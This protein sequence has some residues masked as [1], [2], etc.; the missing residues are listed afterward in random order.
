ME[1]IELII[2]VQDKWYPTEKSL[3][4]ENCPIPLLLLT[5]F[6]CEKESVDMNGISWMF[7]PN[8]SDFFVKIRPTD[9][10]ALTDLVTP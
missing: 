5:T 6:E 1:D 9:F 2:L 7:P 3:K 10:N 8:F 4:A